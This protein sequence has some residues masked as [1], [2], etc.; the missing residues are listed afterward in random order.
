MLPT[1]IF[2]VVLLTVALPGCSGVSSRIEAVK[3]EGLIV[4]DS[5]LIVAKCPLAPN[6][7]TGKCGWRSRHDNSPLQNAAECIY[8]YCN[9]RK[10]DANI[11]QKRQRR[12]KQKEEKQANAKM[13]QNASSPSEQASR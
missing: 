10:R 7:E 12:K 13:C 2:A 3:I 5:C 9:I 8:C 6:P 1:Y 4:I 11:K